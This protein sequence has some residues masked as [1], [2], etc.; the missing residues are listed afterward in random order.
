MG[1]YGNGGYNIAEII[2]EYPDQLQKTPAEIIMK[3][4]EKKKVLGL[5]SQER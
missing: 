4:P 3:K 2:Q 1:K 5:K